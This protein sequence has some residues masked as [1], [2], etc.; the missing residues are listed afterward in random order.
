L[1]YGGFAKDCRLG[2]VERMVTISDRKATY[3]YVD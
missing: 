2:Y 3:G 1:N